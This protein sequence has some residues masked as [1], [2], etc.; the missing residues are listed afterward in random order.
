MALSTY[1]LK[2]TLNVN[3]LKKKKRKVIFGRMGGKS[4]NY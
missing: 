1:L 2:I 3:E 4:K